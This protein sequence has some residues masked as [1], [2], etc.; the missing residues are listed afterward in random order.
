M[1][2]NGGRGTL[3]RCEIVATSLFGMEIDNNYGLEI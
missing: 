1:K 3:G 2:I